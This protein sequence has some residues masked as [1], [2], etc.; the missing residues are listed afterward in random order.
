MLSTHH[1]INVTAGAAGSDRGHDIPVCRRSYHHCNV[2]GL[3]R[4]IS[5][6][7]AVWKK[8]SW[9]R[10]CVCVSASVCACRICAFLCACARIAFHVGQI[11]SNFF[12][13]FP[14]LWFVQTTV[15]S[16]LG[17]TEDYLC[18]YAKSQVLYSREMLH[19]FLNGSFS[20]PCGVIS[21]ISWG[22][23][24]FKEMLNSRNCDI[25]KSELTFNFS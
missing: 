23:S 5:V 9:V 24:K 7:A 11:G 10:T 3:N 12:I 21:N 2:S 20:Y 1:D 17:K 19:R 14:H 18:L 13:F 25:V 15:L 6:L 8:S 4:S 16:L 22:F